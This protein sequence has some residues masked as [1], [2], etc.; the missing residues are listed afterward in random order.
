[1]GARALTP[2]APL[3]NIWRGGGGPGL[4][5]TL[6]MTGGRAQHAV[7]LRRWIPAPY[8]GTGHA[9]AGMTGYAK[10]SEEENDGYVR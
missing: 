6:A 2:P 10:V 7:P 9:F 3:S 1:M 4:R 8:R 5:P